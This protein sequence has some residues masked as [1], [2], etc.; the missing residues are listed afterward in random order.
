MEY[1]ANVQA[2]LEDLQEHPV[3]LVHNNEVKKLT[4]VWKSFNDFRQGIENTFNIEFYNTVCEYEDDN[5][6]FYKINNEKDYFEA[7]KAVDGIRLYLKVNFDDSKV[8]AKVQPP[9]NP[10]APILTTP[11]GCKRC[12]ARN[13]PESIRCKVCSLVRPQ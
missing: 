12:Q 3:E 10:N 4:G 2:L 5:G 8:S 13:V 7:V 1:Y 11:W 6:M 9:V